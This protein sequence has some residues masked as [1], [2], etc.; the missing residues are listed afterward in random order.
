[1][2]AIFAPMGRGVDWA[3]QDVAQLVAGEHQDEDQASAPVR[4]VNS[5]R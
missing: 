1:M 4:Q 3:A 5:V 2:F